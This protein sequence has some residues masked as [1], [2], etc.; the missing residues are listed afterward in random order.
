M[1][2]QRVTEE[3]QTE[4][5]LMVARDEVRR[6]KKRL[7]TTEGC[8]REV[9]KELIRQKKRSQA[10]V[11]LRKL[12]CIEEGVRLCEEQLLKL[13]QTVLQAGGQS[14]NREVFEAMEA[15]TELLQRINA[16]VSV[17]D[18]RRLME[19][20]ETADAYQQELNSVLIGPNTTDETLLQELIAL[21]PQH[22]TTS[23]ALAK[24]HVLPA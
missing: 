9:V 15:G 18:V 12:K 4:A 24:Q 16:R 11:A 19:D 22:T 5:R 10:V 1:A 14:R 3:D 13:E 20:T 8:T 23:P 21:S 17:E 2:T 7:E 6:Y